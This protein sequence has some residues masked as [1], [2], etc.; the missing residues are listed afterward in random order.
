MHTASRLQELACYNCRN[1]VVRRVFAHDNGFSGINIMGSSIDSSRLIL[2]KDCKA[3][4]NPGDP[5]IINNHSGNGI[6]VGVSDSV[7]IDHCTATNNG[8]DMPRQG[9]GP[10]GIWAWESNHVSIQYC[11]SYRN[12]TS[13]GGSD[14]GGFDL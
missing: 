10:V 8:W 12:K 14:G 11:I 3:E 6:L 4:N 9:N 5:A 7:T 13:K 1:M 2:I